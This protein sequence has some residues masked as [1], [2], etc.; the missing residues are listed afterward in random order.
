MKE[1]EAKV[2]TVDGYK[3]LTKFVN[4]SFQKVFNKLWEIKED[5]ELTSRARPLVLREGEGTSTSGW[6]PKPWKPS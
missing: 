5:Y 1:I 4:V 3:N 2:L 6:Q